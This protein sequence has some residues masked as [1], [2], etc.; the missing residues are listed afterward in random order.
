VPRRAAQ[1]SGCSGSS[2]QPSELYPTAGEVFQNG[3][4]LELVRDASEPERLALLY[5]DGQRST[6][7]REIMIAGGR[8]T[9]LEM[10][11]L[12]SQLHLSSGPK[13]YGST[14]QLFN[15]VRG[16]MA[17][18]SELTDSDLWLVTYF[19]FASFFRECAAFAPCLLL[20]GSMAESIALLRILGWL[21]HHAVLLADTGING[22][23]EGFRPTRLICQADGSLEKLLAPLQLSGFGICR[24]GGLRE[25]C[26]T[27]AIYIGEEESC[28]PFAESCLR[29]PIAPSRQLL[30]ASEEQRE[31]TT[32]L[33][34]QDALLC[35]RITNFSR[36][37][38]SDFDSP[39]FSGSTRE[40]AR[41]LGSCIVDSP[42]LQDRLI[43]LLRPHDEAVRSER[44]RNVVSVLLEVLLFCCHKRRESVHV[45]EVTKIANTILS[46]RG[47]TLTLSPRKTGSC[48]EVFGLSHDQTGRWR[49]RFVLPER[50]PAQNSHALM[51]VQ[52]V[53][54]SGW[55][56]GVPFLRTGPELQGMN[57]VHVVH[58]F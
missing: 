48:A 46:A 39:E 15:E 58:I 57:V 2:D 20:S 32:I 37:K 53:G 22:F 34:L 44:A 19:V 12:A 23:P 51:R 42:E 27:T 14:A 30:L 9:P 18:F 56:F 25:I 50:R 31:V 11:N 33:K 17:K 54:T 45:G 16:L 36:V 6:I 21:C 3:A 38:N 41:S 7:D 24:Q 52:N 55:A 5:W 47:E 8:Y 10:P 26:S 29:I 4:I 1:A 13:P 28:S 49:A 40:L 35:Y 43:A